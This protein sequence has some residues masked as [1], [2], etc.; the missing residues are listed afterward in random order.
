MVIIV[1]AIDNS[2]SVITMSNCESESKISC[3]L[4]CLDPAA[5]EDAMK[6]LDSSGIERV[7]YTCHLSG[8]EEELMLIGDRLAGQLA[9]TV[10]EIKD[11]SNAKILVG[12]YSAELCECDVATLTSLPE[13]EVIHRLHTLASDGVLAHRQFHEMNYYRLVSATIRRYIEAVMN[14]AS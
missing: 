3:K 4:R 2:D 1:V 5:V 10:A 8:K 11:A 14:A 6:G 9:E 12:L 7:S 13:C